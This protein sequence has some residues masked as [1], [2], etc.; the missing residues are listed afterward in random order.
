MNDFFQ[1]FKKQEQINEGLFGKLLGKT[2]KTQNVQNAVITKNDN[3]TVSIKFENGSFAEEVNTI[4]VFP[5]LETGE[6][7]FEGKLSFLN[8]PGTKF[9][10]TYLE[11]DFK[12]QI[13]KNFVGTWEAGPFTGNHFEGTFKQGGTEFQG[14]F[15]GEYTN[16]EASP[17]TFIGGTFLDTANGGLLGV[18]NMTTVP[19]APSYQNN[20]IFIPVGYYLTFRSKKG[21]TGYIKVIKRLD[22]V[23]S[24]FK[25]E[26]LDG[27][28]GESSAKT[29][30][31]PWLQVRSGWNNLLVDPNNKKS[32]AGIIN[33]L[34]G[35]RD[36]IEE[37]NIVSKLTISKPFNPKL[38]YAYTLSTIP[39]LAI[40]EEYKKVKLQFQTQ[41]AFNKFKEISHNIKS[42]VFAQDINDIKKGIKYGMVD[43]YGPFNYLKFVFD[44]IQGSALMPSAQKKTT[45]GTVQEVTGA[46]HAH[47]FNTPTSGYGTE[48]EG[49]RPVEYGIVPAMKR[50]NELVEYFVENMIDPV[51]QSAF[52][53]S[54]KAAIGVEGLKKQEVKPVVD[55]TVNQSNTPDPGMTSDDVEN[56]FT[57]KESIRNSVRGIINDNF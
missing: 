27:F 26:I 55:P 7:N 54:L 47:K 37:I 1:Q 34:Q 52:I 50:M 3:N 12:N 36:E 2:G 33:V 23:N 6:F 15:V 25:Y 49:P 56:A 32:V 42:G 41:E 40:P 48:P 8:S 35:D 13:V 18:P 46:L 22:H 10:A 14:D 5:Y 31:I 51:A 19:D 57:V 20:L 43:G 39:G 16:W 44:N 17:L 53:S 38:K 45:R 24:D 11:I 28:K 30:T 29:I 21:V 4:A 9:H